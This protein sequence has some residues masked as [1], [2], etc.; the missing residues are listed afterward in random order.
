MNVLGCLLIGVTM[1]LVGDGRLIPPNARLL[2][3][4]G[5][6]GSFTTF[7]SFGYETTELLA[8]NQY[9]WASLNVG[10]NLALGLAAV[11]MGRGAVRLLLA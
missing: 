2:L 3:L 1:A 5:L 4:V 7:S 11:V 9:V 6:L 8:E 10:A